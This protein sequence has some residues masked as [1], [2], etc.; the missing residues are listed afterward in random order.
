MIEKPSLCF[1]ELKCSSSRLNIAGIRI[2]LNHSS[3]AKMFYLT[4]LILLSCLLCSPDP[5]ASHPWIIRK[6]LETVLC[7]F[8]Q[9]APWI[10]WS[11]RK[12][13]LKK[14]KKKPSLVDHEIGMGLNNNLIQ[15][16]S[17][18]SVPTLCIFSYQKN[19]LLGQ[20]FL[21]IMNSSV[22]KHLLAVYQKH[23]SLSLHTH[24]MV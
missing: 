8:L 14:K 9:L 20:P 17:S 1:S 12:R 2:F 24:P 13:N 4:I 16:L 10:R 3:S 23:G 22:Q 21:S 7:V 5:S 18:C 15:A 19:T 6:H 11:L